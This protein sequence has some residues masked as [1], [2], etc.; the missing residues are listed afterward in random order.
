MLG[1]SGVAMAAARRK[2]GML[3]MRSSTNANRSAESV[4]EAA[5]DGSTLGVHLND[6][7][8][9]EDLGLPTDYLR[10]LKPHERFGTMKADAL[11]ARLSG[12]SPSFRS[13]VDRSK[14]PLSMRKDEYPDQPVGSEFALE[15]MRSS[16]SAG[17]RQLFGR[18]PSGREIPHK[19]NLR[20]AASSA[21]RFPIPE[22][23]E[24]YETLK[25]G[26]PLTKRRKK[27]Q[28]PGRSMYSTGS[29]GGKKNSEGLETNG[30]VLQD[31]QSV[32]IE[33][34]SALMPGQKPG[35][36][37]GPG[38]SAR[39]PSLPSHVPG[40]SKI[41]GGESTWGKSD[42]FGGG[43][44]MMDGSLESNAAEDA[45][46]D[47]MEADAEV[48]AILS[49]SESSGST[50]MAS[51]SKIRSTST[52]SMGPSLSQKSTQSTLRSSSRK[53]RPVGMQI[54]IRSPAGAYVA[55]RVTPQTTVAELRSL[56]TAKT[57][58][59]QRIRKQLAQAAVI[60][61]RNK[62][63]PPECTLAQAKVAN[64]STLQA[65]QYW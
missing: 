35:G 5:L 45:M 27:G 46:Y 34:G 23:L 49:F 12:P 32:L 37:G 44:S 61:F 40:D 28:T 55:L 10:R 57:G 41:L 38:S 20:L 42:N 43:N 31:G 14:A 13:K 7:L 2:K 17:S 18:G 51:R 26:F 63:I 25:K 15:R 52:V 11:R 56:A 33:G 47:E 39:A 65:L 53:L 22:T 3:S 21:A 59:S 48:E 58:L 62:I 54:T 36:K 60:V 50:I 9:D 1:N 29:N 64:G 8:D 19:P 24:E 30:S 6:P 4:P 16:W